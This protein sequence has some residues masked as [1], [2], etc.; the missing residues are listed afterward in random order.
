MTLERRQIVRDS[1]CLAAFANIEGA[2]ASTILNLSE[3]GMGLQ[4]TSPLPAGEGSAPSEVRLSLDLPATQ[5]SIEAR[6]VVAWS[7]PNLRVGV[8]FL[9]LAEGQRRLVREFLSLNAAAE[10]R[11]TPGDA[12]QQDALVLP[13]Q[14]VSLPAEGAIE[15]PGEE[16]TSSAVQSSLPEPTKAVAPEAAKEVSDVALRVVADR[17]RVFTGA[18]G[19]AVALLEGDAMVCRAAC[20]ESVPPVGARLGLGSGI[21]A[22]CVRT[23][24]VL[25]CD[26]AET[27]PGVDRESCRALGIRS[28]VVVPV[29]Q[30]TK[31]V[32]VLEVVS[33]APNAF[34][35]YDQAGLQ[36]IIEQILTGRSSQPSANPTIISEPTAPAEDDDPPVSLEQ[37]TAQSGM[38]ELLE[39][40]R[41]PDSWLMRNRILLG[42]L[43]GTVLG[44]I[45]LSVSAKL[46]HRAAADAQGP[47]PTRIAEPYAGAARQSSSELTK[48]V[49]TRFSELEQLARSGDAAAQFSLGARYATG[50]QLPQDYAEAVKWFSKSAE[51]GHVVAQAALGACY[52]AGRGVSQDYVKS[53]MWSSLAKLGGDEAS[54]Y[55]VTVLRPRMSS[56]Q[57]A[58]ADRLVQVWLREHPERAARFSPSAQLQP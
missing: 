35:N 19:A 24:A 21:S 3:A 45:I 37:S 27:D 57:I 9:N 26:D 23:R 52:W 38:M 40:L 54:K 30:G 13:T 28:I 31:V 17:A 20:G 55:R 47:P 34:A 43:S 1:V 44:L 39:N 36:R 25:R 48:P 51:Q 50:D 58:E 15:A 10:E 29:M 5:T 4:A 2:G 41:Q 16:P 53:Y 14:P 46:Q 7:D 22:E 49:A 11:K 42:A 32:G 33:S 12:P 8:R 18:T 6:G 56:A